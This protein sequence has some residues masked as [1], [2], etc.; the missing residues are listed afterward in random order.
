LT[1]ADLLE[2]HKTLFGGAPTIALILP[3]VVE[4]TTAAVL[5]ADDSGQPAPRLVD[6]QRVVT[7]A[8]VLL[9]HA[10]P[11]LARLSAQETL[12]EYQRQL[13]NDLQIV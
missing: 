7:S 11:L 6:P 4:G 8:E 3:V 9:L 2:T 5:Y 10:I 12:A 13:L 1:P